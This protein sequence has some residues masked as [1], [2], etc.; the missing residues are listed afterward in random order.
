MNSLTIDQALT[1]KKGK[2]LINN[3]SVS[4]PVVR[5]VKLPGIGNVGGFGAKEEDKTLYYSFT[6]YTTPGSTYLYN[7]EEGTSELYRKPNI[8]FNSE[9][10]ES[11]QIFY[12]SKDGTKIPMIILPMDFLIRCSSWRRMPMA[13]ETMGAMSGA[14]SMAPIITEALSR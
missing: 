8:K 3:D 1:Y 10:F 4:Q 14:R 12:T 2:D 13:N 5:E 11:K 6:N 9:D 7:I